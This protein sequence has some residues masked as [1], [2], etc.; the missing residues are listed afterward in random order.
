LQIERARNTAVPECDAAEQVRA[1]QEAKAR[2]PA[3]AIP[4]L[5]HLD[6]DIERARLEAV[7]QLIRLLVPR[8]Q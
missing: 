4:S 2:V 7:G 1:Y 5:Q 8:A 3:N 6:N